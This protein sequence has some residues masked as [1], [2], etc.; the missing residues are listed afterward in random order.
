MKVRMGVWVWDYVGL[1]EAVKGCGMWGV[2]RWV[3]SPPHGAQPPPLVA[4]HQQALGAHGHNRQSFWQH[5]PLAESQSLHV[6]L[7]SQSDPLVQPFVPDQAGSV[8][9][10]AAHSTAGR[11]CTPN[12]ASQALWL[13][14][15]LSS[16]VLEAPYGGMDLAGPA[17]WN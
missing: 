7:Q 6:L 4:Q 12:R 9:A 15:Q 1:G 13:H 5:A 10:Y 3:C 14:V 11:R 8:P 16:G 17:Q 2:C